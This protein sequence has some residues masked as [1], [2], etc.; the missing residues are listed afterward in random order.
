MYLAELSALAAALCWSFGGLISTT[1]TRQL[2]AVR[3]NRIRLIIVFFML[4]FYSVVAGGWATID[5]YSCWVLVLSSLIGIFLGDT[6]LF[7]TLKRLGPRRNAIRSPQR[8]RWSTSIRLS[9]RS[10]G[11]VDSRKR[12]PPSPQLRD[13]ASSV[14]DVTVPMRSGSRWKGPQ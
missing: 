4:L 6:F 7:A 14:A 9:S 13:G 2:G 3:F 8:R 5:F 12:P 1:P 11:S 10:C